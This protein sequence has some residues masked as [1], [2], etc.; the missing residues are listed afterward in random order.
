[1]YLLQVLLKASL[2]DNMVAHSTYPIILYS[3]D[4]M[5]LL[6]S[7]RSQIVAA[8]STVLE[9]IVAALEYYTSRGSTH[10]QY[11]RTQLIECTIL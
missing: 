5:P 9:E 1:M 7:R 3:F 6:L 10:H 4:Q 8:P 11:L 2:H